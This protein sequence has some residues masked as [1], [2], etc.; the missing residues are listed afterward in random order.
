M[1]VIRII[2]ISIVMGVIKV[3]G[4]GFV[5]IILIMGVVRRDF[6][7]IV[8][9]MIKVDGLGFILVLSLGSFKVSFLGV[10]W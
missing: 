5:K 9:G 3:Y 1:G 6:T 7:S 2:I 8:M 4:L 10:P